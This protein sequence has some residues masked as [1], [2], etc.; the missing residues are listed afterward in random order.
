MVQGKYSARGKFDGHRPATLQ[1]D[2]TLILSSRHV[3]SETGRPVR[4]TQRRHATYLVSR[5]GIEPTA[6]PMRSHSRIDRESPRAFPF[7]LSG[8][9]ARSPFIAC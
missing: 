5:I 3:F 2:P 1:I 7:G 6:R 9:K 8:S 4:K